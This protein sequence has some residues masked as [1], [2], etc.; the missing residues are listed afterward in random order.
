MNVSSCAWKRWWHGGSIQSSSK[1]R[2][3]RNRRCR[4]HRRKKKLKREPG[5][6]AK[7]NRRNPQKRRRRE[8]KRRWP[9]PPVQRQM[10]VQALPRAALQDLHKRVAAHNGDYRLL[11]CPVTGYWAFVFFLGNRDGDYYGQPVSA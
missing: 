6:Q 4:K 2:A 11:H 5:K 7:N 1:N 8:L 10:P 9:S 3:R